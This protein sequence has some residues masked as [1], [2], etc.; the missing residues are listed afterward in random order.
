VQAGMQQPT[1]KGP[2]QDDPMEKLKKLKEMYEAN[3]ITEQ[4]YEKKRAE[5]LAN[6]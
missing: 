5:I 4:E 6:L 1:G 2:V 3:L